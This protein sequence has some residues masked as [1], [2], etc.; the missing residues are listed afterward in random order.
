VEVWYLAD[1]SARI[2]TWPWRSVPPMP[3][4]KLRI[5]ISLGSISCENFV[6]HP[7][8]TEVVWGRKQRAHETG[9]YERRAYVYGLDEE[10]ELFFAVTRCSL[11]DAY[12]CI[13]DRTACHLGRR[14]L[15]KTRIFNFFYESTLRHLR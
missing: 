10:H 6:H 1:A 5:H 12:K 9:V 7:I 3:I 13:A 14:F 4:L 2:E 11:V 15:P 8:V